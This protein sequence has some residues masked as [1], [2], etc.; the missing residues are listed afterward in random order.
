MIIEKMRCN[1]HYTNNLK[2]NQNEISNNNEYDNN[3]AN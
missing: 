3:E 2:I 1:D